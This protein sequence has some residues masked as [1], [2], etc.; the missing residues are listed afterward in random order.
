M[1]HRSEPHSPTGPPPLSADSNG[2]DQTTVA[3]GDEDRAAPA[4]AP[5]PCPAERYLLREPRGRG[6]MGQVWLAFDRV[7]GREVALKELLPHRADHELF[8]R[9]LEHE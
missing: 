6:G 3:Q 8:R 7:L 2:L 9:R 5:A 4:E 1:E